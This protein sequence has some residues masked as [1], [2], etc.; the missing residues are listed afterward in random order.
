[1]SDLNEHAALQPDT[2]S[3]HVVR[4]LL[5]KINEQ[6]LRPGDVVE[7]EMQLSRDLAV[8]RGSVR[9][10]RTES[11]PRSE[12]SKSATGRRPRIHAVNPIALTQIFNPRPPHCA[13]HLPL[14]VLEFRR[15]I[16]VHGAQLA[17]RFATEAQIAKLRSPHSRNARLPT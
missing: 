12:Y 5:D 8:S 13:R 10:R 17:A 3:S 14:H 6:Q 7:S 2:V 11:W 4:R 15:G 16:E 1:M 9:G